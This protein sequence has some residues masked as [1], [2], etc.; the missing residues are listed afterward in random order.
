[1]TATIQL[2][3]D[4]RPDALAYI[5]NDAHCS[6]C[7][8]PLPIPAYVARFHGGRALATGAFVRQVQACE[9]GGRYLFALELLI[10]I[11]VEWT[12][13][14]DLAYYAAADAIRRSRAA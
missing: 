7:G 10:G 11:G 5:V 4:A 1:M 14:R 12:C 3:I 2:R 6:D 8:S 13:V 9:C